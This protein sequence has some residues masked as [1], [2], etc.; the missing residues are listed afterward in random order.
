MKSQ[1]GESK[2]RLRYNIITIFIYIVGIV[3][4]IQLFN[5][6]IIH[7]QEYRTRSN[8]RLTRETT[9]EAARGT[10][11]D[12]TGNIIAGTKMGFSLELYRSK[13]D[14]D[15]LNNTILNIIKVLEE[16]GD[17]YVDSFPISINPIKFNL[18]DEKDIIEWKKENGIDENAT[19][20][21]C[22]YFF[23]EKYSISAETI[24]DIRKIISIRYEITNKGYS[25]TK[26]IKIADNISRNSAVILNEQN[27]KFPGISVI[28]EPIRS[29]VG[30]SLASH[31]IGY[32]NRISDKEYNEKKDIYNND[33]YIGQIGIESVFE[34]YL[35]GQDGIKQ[36]DMAVDGTVTDEYVQQEAVSGSNI[37]L[38]LNMNLQAVTEQALENNIKKISSGGF[39][40]KHDAKSGT[41]VVMSVKTGEV[42]AMASYPN[43]EPQLF[44]GG[45]DTKT[46]N[47]YT[48]TNA[49]FNRAVQGAYAPGS[50]FK[51]ATALAALESGTIT[52][53]TKIQTKGQYPL[54]H[55][56]VCWLWSQYR[57]THGYINI[58]EAIQHSCNYFFY[59]VG[60]KMTID[61]IAQ[62]AKY[63]GLGQKTGIELLG[64]ET[65]E[66]ATR[67]SASTRGYEWQI[68][69]TLSASIGQ[70]YNN[71][72]PLQIAKYIS[73]ITNGGK[74]I[75][76]TLIKAIINPDG[77]EIEKQEI[78][79]FVNNKLG[80]NQ[81]KE[82]ELQI[83]QENLDAILTGMKSV[84]SDAG[85]TA[86]STF[87][88]FDIEVGGK[89]GSAQVGDG[90][91][92]AWFAGFAPFKEPEIAVVVMVENGGSRRI[93][94]R[95]CK[96]NNCTIL[97]NECRRYTR[98]SRCNPIY[99]TIEIMSH[100][101][102]FSVGQNVLKGTH[103]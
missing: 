15:T 11:S 29:Y 57:Q 61:T 37:I 62:Y 71:F 82:E 59:D 2:S 45:I 68:G 4:I 34:E 47:T 8:T 36:I 64:E 40:K 41:A 46:W 94:S 67:E 102:R 19:A 103:I 72:T 93:Y 33:D 25:S 3:L 44:I 14:N 83:K 75:K 30:G 27:N 66:L 51:M 49:L 43:F 99:R 12:R 98:K 21:D 54:A 65:G 69:E 63:L 20:Q 58:S 85:G 32:I 88:D 76:P 24:E 96:R 100:W 26:S 38:T 17:K 18:I 90:K 74:A 6:Q 13:A 86:Y 10:I 91:I 48:Q 35:K 1:N 56:P 22:I 39:G 53:Q 79:V 73:I 78:E 77:Q 16:N 84:T 80:L 81:E 70:S 50:I 97:W 42:L 5:L 95:S 52:T 60:Y 55:K 31:V 23:K 9:L 7:G 92:N 89:T 87:R 101:G 28:T